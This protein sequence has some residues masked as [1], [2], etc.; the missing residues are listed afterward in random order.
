M[1]SGHV[2]VP[3]SFPSV[4]IILFTL[5][6]EKLNFLHW[7]WLVYCTHKLKKMK[8]RF[9]GNMALL[10]YSGV[11]FEWSWWCFQV[12]RPVYP[13]LRM[14]QS[15]LDEWFTLPLAI[16][17]IISRYT[18]TSPNWICPCNGHSTRSIRWMERVV[19]FFKDP[20]CVI[21]PKIVTLR[22]WFTICNS[23]IQD[24]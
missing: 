8:S 13:L 3:S 12:S 4:C 6:Q 14:W 20:R 16:S 7:S 24:G 22:K 1:Q 11:F 23:S 10:N 18:P 9:P 5:H 15:A 19:V 21:R 2:W 17:R